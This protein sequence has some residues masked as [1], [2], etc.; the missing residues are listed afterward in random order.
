MNNQLMK[1]EA[2]GRDIELT[3]ETVKNL[4]VSGDASKVS[5]KEVEMYMQLCKAQKLNPFIKEAYLVKYGNSPANMIVGKDVFTKRAVK[6]PKFQG[7]EAGIIVAN[8]KTGEITFRIGTFYYKKLEELVGGYCNVYIKDW[9]V[10]LQHTVD[11]DEFSSG[12]STWKKMPATMIR[13]VALVQALREAFP[14]D[15]QG[16]YDSSEMG[17]DIPEDNNNYIEVEETEN[18]V[19]N[20]ISEAQRRRMFAKANGLDIEVVKNIVAKYGYEST[21]DVSK[22]DYQKICEEIEQLAN[23]LE[24]E[25]IEIS[26]EEIEE[27]FETEE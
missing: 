12:Q 22:D 8:R 7:F 27:V 17:T 14:A 5:D 19:I 24:E 25:T 4:L 15:F 23:E 18:E 21:K 6:N 2:D 10:P 26:E 20:V 16:L 13:K 3:K 9:S 1:Y 11:F